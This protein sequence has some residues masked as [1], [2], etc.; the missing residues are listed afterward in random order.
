MIG[1]LLKD[2][3]SVEEKAF[4]LSRI[5]QDH[6]LHSI[7]PEREKQ[8]MVEFTL[9]LLQTQKL[10]GYQLT[11]LLLLHGMLP[12]SGIHN[13]LE[14]FMYHI[15][16]LQSKDESTAFSQ[17]IPGVLQYP[18]ED[19]QMKV[20]AMFPK[21]ISSCLKLIHNES[22]RIFG[23]ELI[24]EFIKFR[25]IP[26]Q[27]L[28][29]IRNI[30][31]DHLDE[32]IYHASTTHIFA[33]SYWHATYDEWTSSWALL[34]SYIQECLHHLG[35]SKTLSSSDG[36]F[37]SSLSHKIRTKSGVSKALLLQRIL[38][39]LFQLMIRML[40][41]GNPNFFISMDVR[42]LIETISVLLPYSIEATT[43]NLDTTMITENQS[44]VSPAAIL[45]ILPEIKLDC[46]QLIHALILNYHQA[47]ASCMPTVLRFLSIC[48]SLHQA[49]HPRLTDQLLKTL[50][51][52]IQT[53]PSLVS[54]V[55]TKIPLDCMC[56]NITL[57]W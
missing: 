2:A 26:S 51:L 41:A 5:L 3:S 21:L 37:H 22:T 25:N 39:G 18:S 17:L 57:V 7:L 54:Q 13:I 16:H 43:H 53:S 10:L 42:P 36:A 40:N 11:A 23:F 46:I 9:L 28:F 44:Q 32:P 29:Q 8:Q 31:L 52:V 6:H 34:C 35:L 20:S 1:S 33:Y 15:E 49:K 30:C 24:L 55:S 45:L 19:I 50:T 12:L 56:S 14:R 4:I 48:L 47:C 38:H 27:A